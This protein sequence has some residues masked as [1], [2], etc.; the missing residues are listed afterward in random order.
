MLAALK[1]R[2]LELKKIAEQKKLEAKNA[3]KQRM[4]QKQLIT[5]KLKEEEERLQKEIQVSLLT[6]I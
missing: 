5:Q 3:H 6:T 4:H 1:K 2:V